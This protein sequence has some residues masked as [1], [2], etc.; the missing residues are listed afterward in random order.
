VII[1]Q[2]DESAE[3]VQNY[4][5]KNKKVP[6]YVTISGKQVSMPQYMY[7]LS[8]GVTRLNSKKTSSVSVKNPLSNAPKPSQ[9]LIKP[10]TLS[11]TEYVKVAGNLKK[12]MDT[13]KRL[14]NYMITSLGNIR[15][16]SMLDA[17]TRIIVFYGDNKRLPNTVKVEPTYLQPT[18]EAPSNSATIKNLASKLTAG[19]ATTR[20]KAEAIFNWVRDNIEYPD[21]NSKN[22]YYNTKKG[23]LGALKDKLATC[24]DTSHLLVALYRA[25][26]IPARYRHGN[27]YFYPR[28]KDDIDGY[29]K[30]GWYGHVWAQVWVDGKWYNVD[31]I[32]LKNTFGSIKIWNTSNYINKGTYS[33]LPF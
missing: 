32:R 1:S 30:G 9:T 25:S 4:F 31:A 18:T 27:C 2:L 14:P 6:N 28:P 29:S 7:L 15:Y 26:G 13:N 17:Y 19:K 24:C 21:M 16:E 3:S 22:Y 20:A 8:Y 12:F 5:Y 33:K 11:K 23:A 10:V